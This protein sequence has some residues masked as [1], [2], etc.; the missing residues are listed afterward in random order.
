MVKTEVAAGDNIIDKI[1]AWFK[2][3]F[4]DIN[5][6]AF[7][8]IALGGGDLCAASKVASDVYQ[9]QLNG[10][11]RMGRVIS[12]ICVLSIAFG[13]SVLALI[14]TN[15]TTSASSLSTALPIIIVTLVCTLYVSSIFIQAF[16]IAIDTI[17]FC[18]CEDL[19]MN[20]GSAMMPYAMP[21]TL[22]MFIE[23]LNLKPAS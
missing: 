4:Q 18:Y 1:R 7:V 2:H 8:Q 14:L 21:D 17:L 11:M 20:D 6:K 15:T 3:V 10:V 5:H 19:E 23:D 22:K 12:W 13:I 9:K 16:S